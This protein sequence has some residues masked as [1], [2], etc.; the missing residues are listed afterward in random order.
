MDA[1]DDEHQL[2]DD[3]DASSGEEFEAGFGDGTSA[4]K[5]PQREIVLANSTTSPT[6]KGQPRNGQGR[7]RI[8]TAPGIPADVQNLS[9]VRSTDYY[10]KR[11]RCE[12]AISSSGD[13][14][15]SS[16]DEGETSDDNETEELSKSDE[17]EGQTSEDSD[18]LDQSDEEEETD[19]EETTE[20]YNRLKLPSSLLE[21]QWKLE[22]QEK[23]ELQLI[24]KRDEEEQQQ[25]TIKALHSKNQVSLWNF[26]VAVRIHLQKVLSDTNRLP[27]PPVSQ[28]F[29]HQ[30]KNEETETAAVGSSNSSSATDDGTVKQQ[31]SN[32]NVTKPLL[33]QSSL[34]EH[35]SRSVARILLSLRHLQ[36]FLI[37]HNKQ[38]SNSL[39][40]Q[41][42]PLQDSCDNSFS[43]V[44][45]PCVESRK[46]RRLE[47][48]SFDWMNRES[49][50]WS[51]LDDR[52]RKVTSWALSMADQW[53]SKTSIKVGNIVI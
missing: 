16:S 39:R 51:N 37:R 6:T 17:Q 45:V 48:E 5:K 14:A 42:P 25:L 11:R 24:Q 49:S 3:D 32:N 12:P 46:R 43:K 34:L 52:L 31:S 35:S 8:R 7:L 21:A 27:I 13:T 30:L 47:F 38:L 33:N 26:L 19:S 15:L 1:S 10:K 36:A 28:L 40:D 9:T 22:E 23:Q 50:V 44:D 2:W 4:S 53:A 20:E 41:A 18:N 29:H